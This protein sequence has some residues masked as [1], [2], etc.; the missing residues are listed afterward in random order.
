MFIIIAN[1]L[2]KLWMSKMG[3]NNVKIQN[4]HVINL[5]GGDP[6]ERGSY[7]VRIERSPRIEQNLLIVQT[8]FFCNEAELKL[9]NVV[10]ADKVG[11]HPHKNLRLC[12]NNEKP[13]KWAAAFLRFLLNF[14]IISQPS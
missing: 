14:I 5:H 11:Q 9:A 3:T 8:R 13:S 6:F 1:Q 7:L 12:G 2:V 4:D 10:L